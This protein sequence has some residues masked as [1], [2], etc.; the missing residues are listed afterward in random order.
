MEDN[1]V[2]VQEYPFIVFRIEKGTYCVNSKNISTIMQLP[3]YQVLPDAPVGITGIFA[4]RDDII[5]MIDIRTAFHIPTLLQEYVDFVQMLDARKQDHIHWV[6][7][8]ERTIETGEKFTLATDPHKC[9]FGQWYDKYPFGNDAA[10]RHLR[11]IEQPHRQL[12]EAADEAGNCARDC[13][14]CVRGECLQDILKH[15]KEESMPQILNLLEETKEIFRSTVYHE[16]VLVLEDS[17]FGLVVDDVLSV[18]N[19]KQVQ[20]DSRPEVF[21]TPLIAGIRE[22]LQTPGIILELNLAA[23]MH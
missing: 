5:Q 18:E 23:L 19:L 21:D 16:M 10:S 15:V 1:T 20:T 22:S 17:G 2:E 11:K 9:A 6:A 8:L 7:E 3:D 14:N 13:A 4:H 12:H